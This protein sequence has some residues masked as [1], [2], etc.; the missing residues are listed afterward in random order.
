MGGEEYV[1]DRLEI[2]IISL[3]LHHLISHLGE[4]KA[5]AWARGYC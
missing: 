1:L 3:C 5:E 4:K 2:F